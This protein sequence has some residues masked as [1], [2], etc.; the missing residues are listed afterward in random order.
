VRVRIGKVIENVIDALTRALSEHVLAL[1][2]RLGAGGSHS[3]LSR[4]ESSR[5]SSKNPAGEK[6]EDLE[7]LAKARG[8]LSVIANAGTR[9]EPKN[10][11]VVGETQR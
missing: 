3:N 1:H 4:V 9:A 7:V 11:V 8:T 2:S 10:Y 5:S 6:K